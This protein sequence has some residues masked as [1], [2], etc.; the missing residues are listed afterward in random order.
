[1]NHERVLEE[2]WRDYG[3]RWIEFYDMK[4]RPKCTMA[5]VAV[6]RFLEDQEGE[7]EAEE[8]VVEC[9]KQGLFEIVEM[10]E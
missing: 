9:M 10:Y 6:G 1:M 3:R 5:A 4:I 7:S 2:Y 8:W